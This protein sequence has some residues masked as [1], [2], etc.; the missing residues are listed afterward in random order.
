[1]PYL[2]VVFAALSAGL[3]VFFGFKAA[4]APKEERNTRSY[5]IKLTSIFTGLSVLLLGLISEM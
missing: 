2:L 1:M 5:F 4:D 3:A